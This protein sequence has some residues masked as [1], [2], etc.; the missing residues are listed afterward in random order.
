M[1]TFTEAARRKQIVECAIETLATL[2]YAQ[3]SLAQIAKRAGVSKGVI[4]YYF[5][6]KEALFLEVVQ[7]IYRE[8]MASMRPQIVA[9]VTARERLRTYIR[10]NVIYIGAHRTQMTAIR[11]IVLNARDEEGK[12]RVRLVDDTPF[13]DTLAA[14]LQQGQ[15]EGEFRAF[16]ARVMA[17]AIR[18]VIDGLPQHFASHPDVDVAAFAEEIVTL[19]DRATARSLPTA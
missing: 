8:G 3:T 19:F 13:L 1:G 6:S 7:S 9:Q 17:G 5:A 15:L 10:T 18:R 16:D 14:L 11:E 2:G 4:I 12:P